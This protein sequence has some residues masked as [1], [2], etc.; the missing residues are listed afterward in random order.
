MHSVTFACGHWTRPVLSSPLPSDVLPAS[1]MLLRGGWGGGKEFAQI[2]TSV[3]AQGWEWA[4]AHHVTKVSAAWCFPPVL[5]LLSCYSLKPEG[6]F[7]G[8]LGITGLTFNS[9]GV[10]GPGR[11]PE[12]SMLHT[13]LNEL[14]R[15]LHLLGGLFFVCRWLSSTRIP[16]HYITVWTCC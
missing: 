14:H 12:P 5:F 9:F 8:G 10:K 11:C 13:T 16:W 3:Q 2:V 1:T 6:V 4:W 7:N 15:D